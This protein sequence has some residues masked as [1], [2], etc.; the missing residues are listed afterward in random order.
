MVLEFCDGT[1]EE[2]TAMRI[3]LGLASLCRLTGKEVGEG[4][5]EL[6]GE[7]VVSIKVS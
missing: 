3:G 2:G 1:S 4:M 5:G 7:A 6:V